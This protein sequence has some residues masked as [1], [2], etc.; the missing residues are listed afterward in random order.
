MAFP[1]LAWAAEEEQPS[2]MEEKEKADVT[3]APKEASVPETVAF[4]EK[5]TYSLKGTVAAVDPGRKSITL[6]RKGLPAVL[7]HVNTNTRIEVIGKDAFLTDIQPGEEVRAKFNLADDKPIAVK[8]E[9]K[10]EV[11]KKMK[12]ERK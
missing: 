3:A 5:D 12:E 1:A 11:E 2:R 10:K 4:R 7:L 8:L 9:A 6:E